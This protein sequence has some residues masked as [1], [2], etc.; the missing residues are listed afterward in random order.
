MDFIL[1]PVLTGATYTRTVRL[2]CLEMFMQKEKMSIPAPW[3]KRFAFN[4]RLSR[5]PQHRTD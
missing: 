1:Q 3:L 5:S 2:A 4:D